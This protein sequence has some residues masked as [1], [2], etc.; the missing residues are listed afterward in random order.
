MRPWYWLAW[1][2]SGTFFK[3]VC[4]AEIQGRDLLPTSNF[5]AVS[6]HLSNLDPPL[7]GWALE[8]E[9]YYLAKKT[10]WNNPTMGKLITSLN[11]IPVDQERPEM[12]SLKKIIKVLREGH[13][14]IIFPEGSRSMDGKLQ[15]GLPGAG[16]VA[17][18]AQ[19]PIVPMRIFGTFE[20]LP[21]GGKN[22]VP[23][24]IRVIIGKPFYPPPEA[25][26]KGDKTHYEALS[27]LMMDRI[28]ALEWD[29]GGYA[30]KPIV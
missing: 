16:L 14:A 18:K 20:A 5:L 23:H 10:L 12:T 30:D 19:V 28:A 24:P 1:S 9:I 7:A 4:H 8:R 15:P 22:F 11:S 17:I 21:P 29:H 13:N 25:E 3:S 6:N 2:L 27:K 26:A